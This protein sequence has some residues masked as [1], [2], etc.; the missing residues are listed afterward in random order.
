MSIT[1][2]RESDRPQEKVL[3]IGNAAPPDGYTLLFASVS[4]ATNA[5]LYPKLPFDMLK[6]FAPTGTVGQTYYV[7]IVQPPRVPIASRCGALD[8]PQA[9]PA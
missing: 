7:L 1:G 2:R 3:S 5:V 6:D 8:A 9:R 4:L